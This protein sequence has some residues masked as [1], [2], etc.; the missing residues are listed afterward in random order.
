MGSILFVLGPPKV[1]R[2]ISGTVLTKLEAPK[3]KLKID[4]QQ[5]NNLGQL[6][7]QSQLSVNSDYQGETAEARN[8]PRAANNPF[9]AAFKTANNSPMVRLF[10]EALT[11][12]RTRKYADL[13]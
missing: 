1:E 6:Q 13:N 3:L 7:T 2:T 9:D 12:Y 5:N 4:P 10:S 11:V 8:E